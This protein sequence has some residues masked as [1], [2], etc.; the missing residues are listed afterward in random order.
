MRCL[1][2]RLLVLLSFVLPVIVSACKPPPAQFAPP[3]L[4]EVTVA[5]PV[6]KEI[7]RTLEFTATTRGFELVEIRAR[8]KGFLAK[9]LVNGGGRVSAGDLLFEIDPREYQAAVGQA[10]AKLASADSQLTIADLTLQRAEDAMRQQAAT[11]QE[12]DQK[13]ALRDSAK[14]DVDLAKALLQKAELDVEFT[15]IRAPMDG[16]IGLVD[17]D[18]GELV[19]AADAT[20]LA[21][22]INDSKIYARFEID[23]RT[24]LD[25]RRVFKNKRPGEDGRPELPVRMQLANEIGF[26]HEG[27]YDR[28]ANTVDT[29]TGTLLTDAIFD[30]P[31]GTIVPGLFTRLQ[32]VFGTE[33]AMLVPDVAVMSDQIGRYVLIVGADSKVERRDV[34]VGQVFDRSRRVNQGVSAD[35]LVIV[36]GLQ[37]ARPGIKVIAKEAESNPAPATSP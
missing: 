14:A 3:P 36:N 24:L 26:P 22:I 37:R 2:H 15:R 6:A 5:R 27:R 29:S 4:P 8:V 13:K 7:E 31:T 9:R 16:R 10:K 20:L 19:G 32:A 30:N 12:V 25:L 23:E 1:R 33:P 28:G 17:V 11:Q 34:E 18:V 21:T 35:D